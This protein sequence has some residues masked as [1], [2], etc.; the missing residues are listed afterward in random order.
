MDRRHFI[1][2]AG[3]MAVSA[4]NQQPGSGY[5]GVAAV[6]SAGSRAVAL[7]DLLSFSLRASVPLDGEPSYVLRHPDLGKKTVFAVVP[8]EPALYEIDI[9]ARKRVAK[10]SLPAVPVHL[11][12]GGP[13]LLWMLPQGRPEL[14]PFD[15]AHLRPQKPVALD[16]PPVSFDISRGG[17]LACVALENG[18]VQFVDLKARKALPPIEIEPML[19]AV[20]FRN[21][22]KVVMVAGR[23]RRQLSIV[24]VEAKKVMVELPL[25]LRPDHICMKEDGGQLFVTGEGRDGVVIVYPYQTE[26]AQTSLSG[27]RPGRMAVSEVPPFLF[28]ANPDAGSVTVFN[29]STQKVAGVTNVGVEPGP[30]L[31][32]PDQQY[33]LV[34]NQTSGDI[35][36]IRIAAMQAAISQPRAKR[37]PLFT[38]IPVGE[39]P[40]D[41]TVVPV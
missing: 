28:V 10:A 11:K 27:R 40:V 15:A 14:L 2:A 3:A 18:R 34:L 7:V 39:R 8:A 32:T 31:V 23:G 5:K 16:A 41:I 37:A 6:A 22:S 38:M 29:I 4:C 30:I 25:A 26:I 36:V 9:T 1:A 35:A 33:A 19:G 20:L 17:D 21:D 13:A 12:Q 24:S